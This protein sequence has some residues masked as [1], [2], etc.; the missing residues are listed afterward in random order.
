M[1][2]MRNTPSCEVSAEFE[3]EGGGEV[4]CCV[5]ALASIMRNALQVPH[6]PARPHLPRVVGE[7]RARDKLAKARRLWLD[8]RPQQRQPGTSAAHTT[9]A[10][11][12]T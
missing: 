1:Q 10:A 12:Q 9:H 7:R 3:E 2:L 4:S 11:A 8:G 6:T 5:V